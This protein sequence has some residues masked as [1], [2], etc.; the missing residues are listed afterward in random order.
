MDPSFLSGGA[1][2]EMTRRR[3]IGCLELLD[4]YIGRIGRLDGAINAVV[5]KD[6][7]RARARARA[8]DQ[9]TDRSAPLFGVPMT[10][11][12]SFDVA[13]LPST[14]GHLEGEGSSRENLVHRGAAAG[15]GGRRGVR[16]DQR[17]GRSGG[18][19]EL[20]SGVRD[21]LQSLEPRSHAGRIL[22]RVRGGVGGRSDRAW[23][24]AAT[25]VARSACRRIIAACSAIS[26]PGRC[27][28]TTA[29]TTTSQAA[30][31]DIAVLG[32]M[33]RSA[34]DLDRGDEPARRVPIRTRPA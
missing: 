9:A 27:A 17:A 1:L 29:T 16:Q 18:L 20:Q 23:K 12:E 10:V 15:G 3:E 32:P 21:H 6:F 7:D 30:P 31:T 22:G 26:R 25:S 34:D 28:P 33:A 19:A 24:S 4:H 8:L 2:A 13:G 5:V 14:R 11:K